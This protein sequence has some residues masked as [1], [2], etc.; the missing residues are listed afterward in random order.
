MTAPGSRGAGAGRRRRPRCGRRAGVG[1]RGRSTTLRVPG[2]ADDRGG[3]APAAASAGEHS[4]GLAA[5]CPL[6][7]RHPSVRDLRR[8][9]VGRHAR[10]DPAVL[11]PGGPGLPRA[12]PGAGDGTRSGTSNS[13]NRCSDSP[14]MPASTGPASAGSWNWRPR[15]TNSESAWRTS[16]PRSPNCARSCGSP[17]RTRPTRPPT[18]SPAC[19]ATWC[20]G[21]APAPRSSPGGRQVRTGRW[22]PA[23]VAVAA[24]RRECRACAVESVR[25]GW[26]QLLDRVIGT[27]CRWAHLGTVPAV[28]A[29]HL[30]ARRSTAAR[31]RRRYAPRPPPRRRQALRRVTSDG[32][33]RH[34]EGRP[35]S[36]DLTAAAVV[37]ASWCSP[38]ISW[39]C[40]AKASSNCGE[41]RAERARGGLRGVPHRLR[42]LANLVAP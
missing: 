22:I 15:S 35:S 14:R 26:D 19:A 30:R 4:D 29:R 7:A 37:T 5:P 17:R 41:A 34:A 2:R 39:S 38:R 9:R 32:A 28:S 12:H 21:V 31:T 24:V 11:R 42:V 10:P 23:L 36:P 25:S 3:A 33:A 16:R 18:R 40:S 27:E 20:R 1:L 8:G 13:C 6:R